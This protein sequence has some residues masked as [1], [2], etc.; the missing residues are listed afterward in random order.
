M[1]VEC[2]DYTKLQVAIV[3]VDSSYSK[4]AS[5]E[6]NLIKPASY[7]QNFSATELKICN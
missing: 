4:T 2:R 7:E 1:S 5:C 6:L 3:C